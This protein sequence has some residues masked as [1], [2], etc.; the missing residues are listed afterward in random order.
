[1]AQDYNKNLAI[2]G[3]GNIGYRH[4]QGALSSNHDFTI[5]IVDPLIDKIKN[6]FINELDVVASKKNVI[7]LDDIK[8][9]PSKIDMLICATT[10]SVRFNLMM[11][12]I[13]RV[14]I[15]VIIL[16]K[17]VFQQIEHFK[18]FEEKIEHRNTHVFINCPQRY[19]EFYRNVKYLIGD[20]SIDMASNGN[21]WNLASNAIH[22]IDLF[23]F[24][25]DDYKVSIKNKN[26]LDDLISSRRSGFFE[27]KGSLEISNSRGRLILEDLDKY[28]HIQKFYVKTPKISICIDE[29]N[30][31]IIS[32]YMEKQFLNYNF[33]YQ[34]ELTGNYIDEIFE[35]N[36]INLVSFKM[37]SQYHIPMLETFNEHFSRIFNRNINSCPIS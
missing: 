19:Y 17:I 27:I 21:N 33:P 7:F 6:N 4:F 26:F 37:C 25:T 31:N 23:C 24:L 8:S 10:S 20:K 34:S 15:N 12:L 35:G 3:A 28:D 30:N 36:N 9:L 13:D 1:M 5:Y 32:N 29:I 11:K 16:E 18:I 2:V 14:K 22:V